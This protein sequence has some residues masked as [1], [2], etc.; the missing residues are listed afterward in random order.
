LQYRRVLGDGALTEQ[1]MPKSLMTFVAE[2]VLTVD[3]E[4]K[5]ATPKVSSKCPSVPG[6]TN[7]AQ[8]LLLGAGDHVG[9]LAALRGVKDCFRDRVA[10]N[11]QRLGTAC[12]NADAWHTFCRLAKKDKDTYDALKWL[13]E[14][15]VSGE[16]GALVPAEPAG[17]A[18]PWVL[19]HN[20]WAYR[21]GAESL[22]WLGIGC[23]LVG[24]SGTIVALGFPMC[25]ML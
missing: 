10:T 12:A 8:V 5:T 2:C 13:P 17:W 11:V 4:K 1:N 9:P 23:F 14:M 16:E 24:L 7:W 19:F 3:I 21:F 25:I 15:R 18:A 6:D 20:L 22:P